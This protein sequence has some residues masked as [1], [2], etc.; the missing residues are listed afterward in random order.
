MIGHSY[1]MVDL[2]KQ[3]DFETKISSKLE[4]EIKPLLR[5]YAN[6][7]ILNLSKNNEGKYDCIEQLSIMSVQTTNEQ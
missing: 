3:T 5:E 1:F 2:T 7:G 4:Y 6:D